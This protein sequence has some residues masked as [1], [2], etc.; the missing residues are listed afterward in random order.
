MATPPLALSPRARSEADHVNSLRARLAGLSAEK[1]T[2]LRVQ[3][4]DLE[5][6]AL[7]RFVRAKDG[8]VDAAF[9]M[10]VEVLQWRKEHELDLIL[11]RDY[12]F[13]AQDRWGMAYWHGKDRF[14]RPI[15]IIRGVRHDPKIFST[16]S[17]VRYLIWK[18]ESKLMEPKVDDVV[19]ILDCINMTRNNLDMKLVRIIIPLLLN[20][21]PERLGVC[22]V[23]PTSKIMWVLWKMISKT[24]AERTEKKF[25][26]VRESKREKFLRLIAPEELQERFGGTSTA[27]FGMDF[28]GLLPPDMDCGG[29]SSSASGSVASSPAHQEIEIDC[30][31]SR[32]FASLSNGDEN[33]FDADAAIRSFQGSLL[34]EED[35]EFQ[36]FMESRDNQLDRFQVRLRYRVSQVFFEQPEVGTSESQ[37]STRSPLS[38]GKERLPHPCRSTVSDA[39]RSVLGKR[40]RFKRFLMRRVLRQR[41]RSHS[42]AS[43]DQEVELSELEEEQIVQQETPPLLE[44]Q[45]E[46]PVN[47]LLAAQAAAAALKNARTH[48]KMTKNELQSSE[49]RKKI[50]SS[51]KRLNRSRSSIRWSRRNLLGD[52][53]LRCAGLSESS[54]AFIE[55]VKFVMEAGASMRKVPANDPGREINT[56]STSDASRFQTRIGPEYKRFKNKA[57]SGHAIYDCVCMDAWS[58][59]SKRPHIASYMQLPANSFRSCGT[60]GVSLAPLPELLIVNLM[61]PG[62]VPS[63]PFSKKRTDGPGQ[64]IVLFSRL[65]DWAR[66]NPEDPAVQLW[67][68]FVHAFDGDRFRERLKMITR[69]ENPSEISVGRIEKALLK[70]YNGTP[71]LVRPEY[72]FHRGRGYFEIDID[73]H[74]FNYFVLSNAMP[75]LGR[76]FNAILDCALIVQAENDQEMPER[77]LVAATIRCLKLNEAPEIDLVQ[78]ESHKTF[79]QRPSLSHRRGM[80]FID[81]DGEVHELLAREKVCSTSETGGEE[82]T[83]VS[84]TS[85][86]VTIV[87][88]VSDNQFVTSSMDSNRSLQLLFTIF[89]LLTAFIFMF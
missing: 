24:L 31:S 42:S 5:D 4:K 63:G 75:I 7:A 36:A 22:I 40:A 30:F 33:E 83:S 74:L 71:W 82:S 58:L 10:M 23:Y 17:T 39:G 15:L 19:V 57:A 6:A 53:Q 65:S 25:I 81:R 78:L 12:E 41:N 9:N 80:S 32:A 79:S 86:D 35:E 37:G 47:D 43:C 51:P 34:E 3:P 50:G 44:T 49:R 59:E 8:N 16:V 38:D 77:V 13:A 29:S 28:L 72:E 64:C 88:E 26:F 66:A 84:R 2:A 61:M 1:L 20:F 54:E 87:S 45:D 73:Y 68:R 48:Q 70:K 46:G 76:V 89:M 60:N 62:Y 67:S 27:Q 69:L 21:Y 52:T 11:E 55:K 14:G 18:L 85:T 56:W